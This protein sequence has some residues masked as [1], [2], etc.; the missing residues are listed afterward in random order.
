MFICATI[1]IVVCTVPPL[2]PGLTEEGEKV[3]ARPGTDG[4]NLLLKATLPWKGPIEVTVKE[5]E[6]RDACASV[7]GD[8]GPV[9]LK[10]RGTCVTTR[11]GACAGE[12][13]EPP[14]AR[15]VMVIG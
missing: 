11:I 2:G 7:T 6:V 3:T 9:K 1:D 5:T 4:E 10:S 12:C 15:P 13:A 14:A 8:V